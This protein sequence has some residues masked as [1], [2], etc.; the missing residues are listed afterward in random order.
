[1]NANFFFEQKNLNLSSLDMI[2]Y[3]RRAF[4]VTNYLRD[5]HR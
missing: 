3:S 4:P 2:E 5:K 1:M